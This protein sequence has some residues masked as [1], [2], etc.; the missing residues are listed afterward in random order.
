MLPPAYFCWSLPVESGYADALRG[1]HAQVCIIPM[2]PDAAAAARILFRQDEVIHPS[3]LFA[4]GEIRDIELNSVAYENALRIALEKVREPWV[5]ALCYDVNRSVLYAAFRI[6]RLLEIL[7]S[8]VDLMSA[9]IIPPFSRMHLAHNEVVEIRCLE[10]TLAALHHETYHSAD[11]QRRRRVAGLKALGG[12]IINRMA[13]LFLKGPPGSPVTR[14]ACDVLFAGFLGTDLLTQHELVDRVF[15]SGKADARWFYRDQQGLALSSDEKNS[16]AARKAEKVPDPGQCFWRKPWMEEL[17]RRAIVE[18]LYVIMRDLPLPVDEPAGGLHVLASGLV[19]H[20]LPLRTSYHAVHDSMSRAKPRVVVTNCNVGIM[21]TV[22]EWARQHQVRYVKTPH[23]FEYEDSTDYEWDN[24]VTGVLGQWLAEQVAR[25]K[26]ACGKVYRAGGVHLAAQARRGVA[27]ASTARIVPGRVLLL[28]SEFLR[29]DFPDTLE[30]M[31]AD[32]VELI[33]ALRGAGCHLVIR[34]HPRSRFK[35]FY[36]DVIASQRD[37]QGCLD[38]FSDGLSSLNEE[39][40][41]A[42]SA[43]M[44]ISSSSAIVA[45]YAHVPLI[46]WVPRAGHAGSDAFLRELPVSAGT[47]REL[48]E[49]AKRVSVDEAY[50]SSM[51]AQQDAYLSRIVEDPWGDPWQR[52]IDVIMEMLEHSGKQERP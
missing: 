37:G 14:R 46:G 45:M 6:W 38:A 47:T 22:R 4:P 50:R 34:S 42:G 13:P 1:R 9:V 10:Q 25:R 17:S 26:P 52:S 51:I 33:H 36:R 29:T 7:R 32:L 27:S 49:L 16:D 43:I 40:A 18:Q 19:H 39:L 48:A 23:A 28:A 41:Q 3:G 2:R 30:Q 11:M 8:R 31:Q 20:Q 21:A 35:W 12:R 44:R 24:D 15:G 5:R